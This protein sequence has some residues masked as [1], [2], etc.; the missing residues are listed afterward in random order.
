MKKR[1]YN[2]ILI[3]QY[4]KQGNVCF[5]CKK[6][7][8]FEDITRDHFLPKSKGNNLIK[9]KVFCCRG[10]NILKGDKT[11]VEFKEFLIFNIQKILKSIVRNN[12]KVNEPQIKKIRKYAAILKTVSAI[13]E[14]DDELTIFS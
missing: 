1:K 4:A 13:I 2:K 12:W 8:N 7:V 6:S 9:N 3:E 10:C 11:L 5:Y 14:N